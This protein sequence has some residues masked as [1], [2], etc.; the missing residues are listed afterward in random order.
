MK[1]HEDSHLMIR[2]LKLINQER[3]TEDSKVKFTTQN[4]IDRGDDLGN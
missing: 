4:L 1:K 2:T 3:L